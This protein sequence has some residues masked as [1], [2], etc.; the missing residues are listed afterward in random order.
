MFE[1]YFIYFVLLCFA[2][3]LVQ[4]I[5]L[6]RIDEQIYSHKT[7]HVQHENRSKLYFLP[8]TIKPIHYKLRMV[9]NL[10]GNF[11]FFGDVKIYF[12]VEN[13]TKHVY[14]HSKN[15][16]ITS[17][18]IFEKA[19]KPGNYKKVR[20]TFNL[21]PE[22]DILNITKVHYKFK[23]EQHKVHIKFEGFLKDNM[24]GFYRSSYK[25]GNV[26]K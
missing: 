11:N 16:K 4:S 25:T 2:T 24:I 14:L 3:V 9:P 20:S 26:T 13:K 10:S 7:N 5:P 17:L 19:K 12:K 22:N 1:V 15:L 6:L 8:E 18:S 23:T 21:D